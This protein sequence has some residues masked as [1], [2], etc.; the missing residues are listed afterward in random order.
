MA[1][2]KLK[3]QDIKKARFGPREL[4]DP[5]SKEYAIQTIFA[6]KTYVQSKVADEELVKRELEEV[7]KYRHWEVLGYSSENELLLTE[8]GMVRD[9]IV[10]KAEQGPDQ[11]AE[12]DARKG[13]RGK[14]VVANGNRFTKGQNNADYLTRRIA[15]HH[16]DILE[17]MKAGEFASVRQA[18]LEAGIVK[19]TF[20][21]PIEPERAARLIRKHFDAE[22]IGKIR[23]L[24][25]E[26]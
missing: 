24:L 23:D 3:P 18:A 15:R 10:R 19:P 12:A 26:G 6:L 25:S 20:T 8:V 14:K 4:K 13:G 11:A 5:R 22:S 9:D 17:R 7:R 16:P 21:C 1:K 2:S